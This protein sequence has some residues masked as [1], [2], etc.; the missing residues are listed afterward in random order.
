ML[1]LYPAWEKKAVTTMPDKKLTDKK[2]QDKE[3][4]R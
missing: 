4:G 3:G 2:N 1:Y